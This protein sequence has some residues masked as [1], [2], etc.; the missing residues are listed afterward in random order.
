MNMMNPEDRAILEKQMCD[1][2]FEGIEPKIEGY[3]PEKK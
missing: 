2:L 3:V 1:Y